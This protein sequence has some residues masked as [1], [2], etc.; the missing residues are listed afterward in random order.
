MTGT[1]G[2]VE[3]ARQMQRIGEV[4]FETP[5]QAKTYLEDKEVLLEELAAAISD[6]AAGS[7]SQQEAL[8]ASMGELRRQLKDQRL[9]EN[10]LSRR[11]LIGRMGKS[12]IALW[13]GRS[14]ELGDAGWIP[15]QRTDKWTNPEDVR[16]EAGR[17][18]VQTRAP[19][20]EP[21][22]NLSTND[23]YLIN[24]IYETHIMTE[25]A[26]KSAMMGLVTHRPM[27]GP[28]IHIP[29]R[30]R[31][32]VELHWLTSYGEEITGSKPSMGG[33]VE[34]KAYTLAGFIPWFDEFE[35]DAY[36]DLGEMFL[37]EFAESWGQEFDRQCLIADAAPFTG[38]LGLTERQ[39]HVLKSASPYA[40]KWEDFR[41]AELKVPPEERRHCAWFFNETILH[42]ATKVKDADGDPLWRGPREGKPGTI[43]GY[44]YHEVSIL[45]AASEVGKNQAFAV[46]MNPK[47]VIHG[48]RKGVELKRF[49]GTQQSLQYGELFLRFRKRSGFLMTR[50]K[51]NVVVVK[52]G[53]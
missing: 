45:P 50:T 35:E 11:E 19:L 16:W 38:A 8:K 29:E 53:G 22:G 21:M 24:P 46:F 48:N 42:Q 12:L 33:R 25:A 1:V 18:F 26:K 23:Q 4:G 2:L 15:N 51:K 6:L 30:D 44:A 7:E 14:E 34:L 52:T 49:D 32:G 36:A 39:E 37:E 10:L 31:G 9:P 40:M 47:R 43:D 41:D 5:D 3:R 17:G 27:A 28:S 13:R 20:S